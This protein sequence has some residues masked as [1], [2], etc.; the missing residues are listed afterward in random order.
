MPWNIIYP[1]I[2][3]LL[4]ASGDVRRY[5]DDRPARIAA[6]AERRKQEAEKLEIAAAAKDE[7]RQRDKAFAE[8][9]RNEQRSLNEVIRRLGLT[10][11]SVELTDALGFH[12]HNGVDLAEAHRI[13]RASL[14]RGDSLSASMKGNSQYGLKLRQSLGILTKDDEAELSRLS[15]RQDTREMRL[16]LLFALLTPVAAVALAIMT[17]D[18]RPLLLLVLCPWFLLRCSMLQKSI[19][20]RQ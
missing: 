16:W 14:E 4:G 15:I 2:R 13:C 3:G 19:I 9:V 18:V 12:M 20:R 5:Q 6:R 8:E 1:L 11:S 7:A 17:E 10:P